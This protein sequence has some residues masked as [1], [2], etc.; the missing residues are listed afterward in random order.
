VGQRQASLVRERD[1]LLDG[2]KAA[3]VAQVGRLRA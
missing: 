1:E 2:V 3:L